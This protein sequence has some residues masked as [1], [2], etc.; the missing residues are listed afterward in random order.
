MS[1]D[2]TPSGAVEAGQ[3]DTAEQDGK[4]ERQ[5]QDTPTHDLRTF[6]QSVE[7]QSARE[8]LRIDERVSGH[9]E[10][11]AIT[12]ELVKKMR[13]PIICYQQVEG[14]QLPVVHNVCAS[15]SRIAKSMGWTVPELEN[16]LESAYDSLIPPVRQESGPV[17]ESVLRGAAVDLSML[18]AIRYT[19]SETHPYLSAFHVVA[20]DPVSE[21]LNVSV[22]RLMVVSKNALTIYMTPGGHLDAIF[23]ANADAGR[24][25]PVA[26]FCGAHPLWSLGSLAA[27]TLALDELSVVGGLLGYPLPVVPGLFAS[28][29]SIPSHSELVLEGELSYTELDTE[30]PYGEAFGFVSEVDSRPVFRVKA[31]SHRKEPMFQDI[32]PGQLEHLTMTG[33]CTQVHLKKTLF[34]QYP[35]I[36]NLFLPTPMTVHISISRNT[37]SSLAHGIIRRILL[38][39]RFVKHVV[40]FDDEVDITNAKQTQNAIAMHVQADRDTVILPGMRGNGLDPSELDGKTTKWGIDASGHARAGG[41]AIRNRIPQAVSDALDIKA[42]LERARRR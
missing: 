21:A 34:E 38:E 33:V 16:R 26:A 24:N 11:A 40:L 23:Q 27:G 13:M 29:L 15:L 20:W 28:N 1:A 42:L 37:E 6:M 36:T 31:M 17:R 35:C 18:P 10:T 5:V 2:S 39:H 4:V 8:V 3:P 22:H 14:T 25:T 41:A 9:F 32:V 30:G 19:E 12:S 7:A